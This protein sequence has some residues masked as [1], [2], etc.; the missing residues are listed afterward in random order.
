V[1]GWAIFA[2]LGGLILWA[3]RGAA[4]TVEPVG[5]QPGPATRIQQ[6]TEL[7]KPVGDLSAAQAPMPATVALSPVVVAV[8]NPPSSAIAPPTGVPLPLVNSGLN[9]G[10]GGLPNAYAP[11]APALPPAPIA[12]SLLA[13]VPFKPAYPIALPTYIAPETVPM[14][15]PTTLLRPVGVKVT[16]PPAAPPPDTIATQQVIAAPLPT[17]LRR[18]F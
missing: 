6:N 4:K 10:I 16:T 3:L 13:G 5:E 9:G 2:A 7:G 18:L 8:A 17:G 15:M 12:P 14:P 11:P 1:P